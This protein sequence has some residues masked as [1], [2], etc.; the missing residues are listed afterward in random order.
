[1]LL[2]LFGNTLKTSSLYLGISETNLSEEICI[3]INPDQHPELLDKTPYLE[4]EFL[5]GNEKISTGPLSY[6]EDNMIRFSMPREILR[7]GPAKLQL[8]FRED[9][10]EWVWKTLALTTRIEYSVN[11]SEYYEH[12]TEDFISYVMNELTKKDRAV[13]DESTSQEV[14]DNRKLYTLSFE[15]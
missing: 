9:G 6:D 11:A 4:F 3:D 13:V 10:S 8:V 12:I 5:I 7:F 14:V 15:N 2:K 1:M